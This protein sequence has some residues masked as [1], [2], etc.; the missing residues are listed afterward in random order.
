[1]ELII[2]DIKES[3]TRC[4]PKEFEDRITIWRNQFRQQGIS[5]L[6]LETL[7][8]FYQTPRSK[9]NKSIED[10]FVSINSTLNSSDSDEVQKSSRLEID[11]LNKEKRGLLKQIKKWRKYCFF[12]SLFT[13]IEL[14]LICVMYLYR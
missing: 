6:T 9:T 11:R 13:L 3:L 5:I 14:I 7:L 2:K 1:M 10:D 8:N 4:S 12:A